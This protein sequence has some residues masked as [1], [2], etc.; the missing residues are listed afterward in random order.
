MLKVFMLFTIVAL[1]PVISISSAIAFASFDSQMLWPVN[2][3]NAARGLAA[4]WIVVIY[5]TLAVAVLKFEL[6]NLN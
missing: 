1:A 3:T 4:A 2:W 6:E 5:G